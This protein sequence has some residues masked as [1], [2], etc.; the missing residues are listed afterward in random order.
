MKLGPLGAAV[1]LALLLS[2]L[3]A[4]ADANR[5][6]RLTAARAVLIDPSGKI[7][8]AKDVDESHPPA[9]LVKMM[10]LYLAL[11][12]IEAGRASMDDLVTITPHAAQTPR[13]RMGLRVGDKVPFRTLLDGVGI[14]SANDAAT[15]VAEHLGR[16]IEEVFVDR[17]NAKAKEL[18]L[19]QTQ[20]ANPHGLPAATQR[21]TARDMATLIS[22]LV[23]DHPGSRD[24]LGGQS[25]DYHNRTYTRHIPLFRDPGGVEALK[26]GFTREAGYNLAVTSFK[27][28]QQFLM[29]VLGAKTRGQSFRDAQRMLHY[30]YV[31]AG[32]EKDS[33]GKPVEPQIK[34]A[35]VSSSK[36]AKKKP[37]RARAKTTTPAARPVS[38]P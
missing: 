24:I 35:S 14:A 7:L 19:T 38:A 37:V 8:F 33:S 15:A 2:P 34:K 10:T 22:R 5:P 4:L 16:G 18:G 6:F 1:S 17:M 36:A 28:G 26:T 13:Y 12:D 20:F 29:I 32:L 30:G 21:S 27:S 11:E 3:A 31:E 25:F 9:S 23:T